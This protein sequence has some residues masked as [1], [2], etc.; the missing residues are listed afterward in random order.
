MQIEILIPVILVSY[1]IGS[2]SFSRV[3][4]RIAAPGVDVESV[5]I[6]GQNVE[7]AQ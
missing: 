6:P 7:Q 2:I 1:L 3:V 4:S 5:E